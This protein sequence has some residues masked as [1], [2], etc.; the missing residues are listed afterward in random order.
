MGY[1]PLRGVRF[2]VISNAIGKTLKL[3]AR[4]HKR[5][6]YPFGLNFQAL[7]LLLQATHAVFQ[8]AYPVLHT[9]RPLGQRFQPVKDQ[10]EFGIHIL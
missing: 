9:F 1:L 3:L 5:K 8:N 7:H 2:F 10:I 4:F 6:L